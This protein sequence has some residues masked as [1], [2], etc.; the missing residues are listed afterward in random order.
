MS[1]DRVSVLGAGAW[2][3]ALANVA[4]RAGRRVTLWARDSKAAAAIDK[5]RE[6]PRLPG[7]RLADG[8][9]VTADIAQ[10]ARTEAVLLAVPAQELRQVALML[11]DVLPSGTPVIACAKGIERGSH[12]FMTEVIAE[13]AQTALPA[14]LSGPSFAADVARG[15]PTAVTLAAR[16]LGLAERLTQA[17]GSGSFRPYHSTDVR[18]VEIGGAA[19]NVLAIAAGIAMGRGLGASAVAALTTRGFAELFRF[20]RAF[21]AQPETLTGLSGLGDLVL[22]CSSPQSRNF[23]FGF[24]L[25][26]GEASTQASHGKLTEGAFTAQAL[27]ELAKAKNVDMPIAVAIAAVLDGRL[28]VDEAIESLMTRPFKSEA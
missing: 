10:A 23:S 28:G 19:K 5:S 14:I 18:G 9:A 12:R 17:L 13:C 25:G 24:A 1:L 26:K 22:T 4:A 27:V 8:I 16:D 6:N 15:L 2:G 11:D 21:G 7:M 3:S 20:G